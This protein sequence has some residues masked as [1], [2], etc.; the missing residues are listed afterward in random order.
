M[1]RIQ[2][3]TLAGKAYPLNFSVR[4][5]RAVDEKYGSLDQMGGIFGA[6]EDFTT[7]L[8][9]IHWL[10]RLLM[11]QGAAYLR[12][13]EGESVELPDED[14]LEVLVGIHNLLEVQASLLEAIG[15][16]S[17]TTVEVEPDP[18]NETTTQSD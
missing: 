14:E 3:V 15:F 17:K 12:L 4:A 6:A 18:K 2:Y 16:G 9:N 13:V 1:E 8:Y 7:N 5:A 11:E 10:L